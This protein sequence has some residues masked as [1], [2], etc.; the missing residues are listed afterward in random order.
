MALI[1][2]HPAVEDYFIDLGIGDI[3]ARGGI[4]DLF[5]EGKV[6]LLKDYRL[7]FDFAS[8]SAL[9]KSADSIE[10]AGV[11]KKLKKMTAPLFFEGDPPTEKDG[12]LVFGDSVRQALFDVICR[13]DKEI[14]NRA[15]RALEAAHE[16]LLRLFSICFPDYE[17]FRTVPSVRLTRTLFENLHWDNHSIDDD[18]HQARIFANLDTRPRIWHVG[19]RF[20]DWIRMHYDE[21]DLGR[22]AGKDPNLLIDFV[23]GQVF[24]GTWNKWMDSEPRHR[25]AFDPGE[26][27]LGESRLISHQIYYGEAAMVYMWFVRAA[28]MANPNN[29][30]NLQVEEVHR[31]MAD[32]RLAAA[33]A[34]H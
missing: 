31:S 4:A 9:A 28:S 30:F 17:P 1:E 11:R 15:A 22:F 18:F 13:G 29:R 32:R 14:F 21:Y 20:P 25:I 3:A 34:A 26:V 16:E 7:D 8:L 33:A 24:G 19:Q 12:R 23:T 5:E 10:D 27:W 6:I 2:R